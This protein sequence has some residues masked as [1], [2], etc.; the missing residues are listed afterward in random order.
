MWAL[1]KAVLWH[2]N[3]LELTIVSLTHFV[4]PW[5]C[6]LICPSLNLLDPNVYPAGLFRGGNAEWTAGHKIPINITVVAIIFTWL[7]SSVIRTVFG[8]WNK[9]VLCEWCYCHFSLPGF[10]GKSIKEQQNKGGDDISS[11]SHLISSSS[12]RGV[13]ISSLVGALQHCQPSRW[14]RSGALGEQGSVVPDHHMSMCK[15][16]VDRN[17]SILLQASCEKKAFCWFLDPTSVGFLNR[18]CKVY[19]P[20][21]CW[22]GHMSE[23]T[24][25]PWCLEEGETN[26]N[27]LST[28]LAPG[29]DA[30]QWCQNEYMH[31]WFTGPTGVWAMNNTDCILDKRDFLFPYI[32]WKCK[33]KKN[34]NQ[35]LI[36]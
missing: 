33:R 34:G 11:E 12:P 2:L 23:N 18:T 8:T 17:T 9:Y 25:S 35:W 5:P 7:G 36:K 21:M 32:E 24:C 28:S 26:V 13:K 19:I 27:L 31:T 3:R 4:W 29:R 30:W 16:C 20:G 1:C 6:H 22:V 14:A 15:G 10:R